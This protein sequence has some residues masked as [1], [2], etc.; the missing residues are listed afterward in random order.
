MIAQRFFQPI[1]ASLFLESLN[2][3]TFITPAV[4]NN[5]CF[6]TTLN[7]NAHLGFGYL[8]SGTSSNTTPNGFIANTSV[9]AL[10]AASA[11]AFLFQGVDTSRVIINGCFDNFSAT[12]SFTL[13]LCDVNIKKAG[14]PGTIAGMSAANLNTGVAP[15]PL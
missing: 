6:N 2:N 13:Q 11:G 8:T 4:K 12:D 14:L 15:L 10:P 3:S 1:G 7:G 9:G 5:T